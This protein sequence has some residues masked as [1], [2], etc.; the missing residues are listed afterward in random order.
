[1]IGTVCPSFTFLGGFGG[2]ACMWSKYRREQ[3]R[4]WRWWLGRS[5]NHSVSESAVESM[6]ETVT[7]S[8]CRSIQL[9]PQ[10]GQCL[11]FAPGLEQ[12]ALE[13]AHAGVRE[14]AFA[15]V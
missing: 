1:M 10:G 5:V 11:C 8:E 6:S 7:Q 13:C 12:H 2:F 3:W 14:Q 15:S 9:V 4:C